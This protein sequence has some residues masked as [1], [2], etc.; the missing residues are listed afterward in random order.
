MKIYAHLVRTLAELLTECFNQETLTAER[1]L[2]RAIK[3]N[4]KW[5]SRDRAFMHQAFYEIIRYARYY[6]QLT[7][8]KDFPETLHDWMSAFAAWYYLKFDA[9]LPASPEFEYLPS[10]ESVKARQKDLEA[11]KAI[12]ESIPD[13]LEQLGT[14]NFGKADWH[15]LI[16]VLNQPAP[17]IVRANTLKGTK[18]KTLELLVKEGVDCVPLEY[19]A[20]QLEKR[21]NLQALKVFKEG[22][23]EIQDAASQ[24]VIELVKPTPGITVIDACAGAGGK[25]LNLAAKM[26]NKG[27]IIAMDIREEKLKE[28]TLRA[29]RA[30]VRC[31]ET[32]LITPAVIAQFYITADLLLLDVPCSGLG[33]LR[34]KPDAKW[35]MNNEKLNQLIKT[36]QTIMTQYHNMC[37]PGGTLVYVT[38]SFLPEENENQI[39]WFLAQE[40]GKQYTLL[41]SHRLLPHTQPYDG[42]FVAKLIRQK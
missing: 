32:H 3:A 39:E 24:Q 30:G 18:N 19:N 1:V 4:P 13:W 41:E 34:R 37:K 14:A 40:F 15:S 26:N 28:L 9:E 16:E 2:E 31:A 7:I 12:V 11:D 36:Q 20:I 21:I 35:K 8:N 29:K 10:L 27:R 5:G 42:F 6:A 25:T 38:C 33:I 23:I 22:Y 17:F